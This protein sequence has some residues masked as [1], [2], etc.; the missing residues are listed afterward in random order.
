[1]SIADTEVADVVVAGPREILINGFV[2][3]TTT[4][5]I[6]DDTDRSYLYDVVVRGPFSEQKIELRVQLA[7]V[8][9]S[10]AK[11]FGLDFLIGG[12]S[13]DA[14]GLGGSY[15]GKVATPSIPLAAFSDLAVEDMDLALRYVTGSADV[16][17]MLRA[18]KTEGVIKVLA[19]PNV[20][21]ASGERANFLSGGE[22]PVPIASAGAQGGP[23]VTIEWKEFGVKVDFVPT[24]V[25]EGV[26]S[27]EVSPEV[28]SLDFSNG[29]VLS[30]FRVPA[31]R[32]RKASTTVELHNG[33][34]LVIGGLLLEEESEI[35][36]RT[37]LLGDIPVLGWL[38]RG[39]ET[40]TTVSELMLVVSPNVV[41]A[42]PPGTD[43]DLPTDEGTIGPM[44]QDEAIIEE[45]SQG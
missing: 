12:E 35:E 6:W 8:N 36:T 10:R 24:I 25:D 17:A 31:L 42:L 28:S 45:E 39:K 5:V 16:S 1:M 26:I 13:G 43:L 21:A 38:F 15:A 40:I 14:T 33:E 23:T 19:E 30:G 3:G 44:P 20:V 9:H 11:E 7:E 22:I 18:L 2:V 29:I 41:R 32:S 34:I 4:L 37:W 27:L